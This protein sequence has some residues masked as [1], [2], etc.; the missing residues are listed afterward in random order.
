MKTENVTDK[1]NKF[2]AK[3]PP[4]LLET[5]KMASDSRNSPRS[6]KHE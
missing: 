2:Q 4:P 5:V 6:M 3:H 1:I